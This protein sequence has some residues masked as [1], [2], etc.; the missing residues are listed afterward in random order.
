[1][2]DA[3]FQTGVL[4][5]PCEDQSL[6]VELVGAIKVL[7][8]DTLISTVKTVLKQPPQTELG[9]NKVRTGFMIS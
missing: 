8:M 2:L 1:M 7:P 3:D 5:T 4:P 9:K 6:L